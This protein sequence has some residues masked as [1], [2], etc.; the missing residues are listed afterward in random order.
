MSYLQKELSGTVIAPYIT[1]VNELFQ[2][3]S[4]LWPGD[5]LQL[6]SHLYKVFREHTGTDESFDDFYFWGEVLLSDFNDI[7][8]YLIE[9]ED[10][11]TS[12]SD[13]K[14]IDSLF[15]YLTPEQKEAI[16]RFW[17][18]MV[19]AEKRMN[20]KNFIE[21]WHKLYPV[22]RDFKKVLYQKGLAY[23]GMIYR[24]VVEKLGKQN[25]Q[26]RYKKYYFAGLNA[27][28][29]CE[30][31]LFAYLK[32]NGKAE[33]LWD[34]HPFY[35]DDDSN[36]A[37][38]FIR[39]NLKIF[40]PP[41]DFKFSANS[42]GGPRSIKI[43]SVSS[44]YG[45]AQEIPRFI[46][47]IDYGKDEDFDS[48]AVIIAD[49]SLLFPALGALPPDIKTVNVTMGY[50]VKNSVVFGFLLLLVSLLKNRK[51]INNSLAV[52]YHRYVTNILN[53]QLLDSIENDHKNEFIKRIREENILE[54]N[55]GEIDFSPVHK[56]IFSIPEKVSDF[57]SYFLDVVASLYNQTKK[58]ETGNQLIQEILYSLYRA[59]GRLKI[60][61]DNV[62]MEQ[63]S[64]ISENVYFRLFEQFL[65]KLS[66]PFE[67]EPLKGMQ[68][69]GILETRCLD[70]SNIIVLGFNENRWPDTYTPPSFIPYNIKKGFGMPGIDEQD[71]MYACYF[72]RLLP[73]AK[74]ITLTYSTLKEGIS[75]GEM[76]RYGYQL[77]YDSNFNVKTQNLDYS[78]SNVPVLPVIVPNKSH[79]IQQLLENNSQ[80]KPLSPTAI[81]IFLHC[82]LQFYFRYILKLPE[83]MEMKDE[84]DSPVFGNIFHQTIESV[85]KPLVGQRVTKSDLVN[86]LNDK[87]LIEKEILDAIGKHYL[88][89][90]RSRNNIIEPKGK[91]IL[92]FENIKLFLKRLI[93]VDMEL[94]PF[95]LLSLEKSYNTQISIDTGGGKAD[96]FIGGKIDR[97]DQVNG[98]IRIL[99]YK[100]GY[101]DSLSFNTVDELFVKENKKPKKEILQALLYSYI[102]KNNL[103]GHYSYNPVIYS[104][105]RLFDDRFNPEIKFGKENV[106]V[107]EIEVEFISK[108]KDLVSEIFSPDM[109][110]SQTTDEKYCR[111]CPYNK[112]CLRY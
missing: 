86:I 46:E 59:I 8:S 11:F 52:A 82:T 70:F 96:L 76:S 80:L 89:D 50:P 79:Y 74:N 81:N 103:G 107:Q 92:I 53:H 101:V 85:Y 47:D 27:L 78:F 17:G 31:A 112:I 68:V 23:T 33:F 32:Q 55:L 98:K 63:G 69:M 102:L 19:G 9:A 3:H 75:T 106:N 2:E 35:I 45:Q 28:N 37:G 36:E 54:I 57:S 90:V 64:E 97:I 60:L 30:K 20:Q 71:A 26:F 94:T 84:I 67:G 65:G 29:S 5:R 18:C 48:T 16:A 21:L 41:E 14:E 44:N 7:D 15:Y 62:G 38:K 51:L 40:P 77:I 10:I 12:V 95:D 72:Y 110:F 24:E 13:L 109:K 105:R 87:K 66:V 22:Y 61:M 108:L 93:T 49:E 73:G 111:Y 34:Y 25:I 91:S 83:P 4:D 1:Q 58:A 88:K 104:L 100:T 99:D 56:L 39:E 43:V 42:F 6:I